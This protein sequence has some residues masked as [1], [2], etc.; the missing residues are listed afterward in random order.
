MVDGVGGDEG[1]AAAGE[2]AVGVFEV[3]AVGVDGVVGQAAF[4]RQVE[5]EGF[6]LRQR[7]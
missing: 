1:A 4:G 2:E 5:E 3:A 6:K 7:V